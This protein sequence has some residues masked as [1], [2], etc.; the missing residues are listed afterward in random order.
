MSLPRLF[1]ERSLLVSLL[2]LPQAPVSTPRSSNRTGGF[3]ASGSP[4]GFAKTAHD[5]AAYLRGLRCP[6]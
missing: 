6:G 4:T 1:E 2:V 5:S 3:T